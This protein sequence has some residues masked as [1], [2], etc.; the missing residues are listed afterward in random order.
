MK[1]RVLLAVALLM[2][3]ASNSR[4]EVVATFGEGWAEVNDGLKT[5][6]LKGSEHEMGR[7]Y[8]Y[9]VGDEIDHTLEVLRE[10]A[11]KQ[12]PK[13]RLLP[14]W[15]FRGIGRA[16]GWAWW[17][18]FPA[19]IKDHLNGVIEGS[20]LR[21]KPVELSKA[22]LGFMNGIIDSAGVL[23]ASADS[24]ESQ[25]PP[26]RIEAAVR[27]KFLE[28]MG[29]GALRVNCD[30]F[31]AWGSRTVDGKT[32]QTR[33]VDVPTGQGLET[34]PLVIIY[35]PEGRIPFVTAAFSG[36]VGVFT[37]MNAEGVAM[38]QVWAFSRH[39]GLIQPWQL[40]VREVMM[41]ARTGRE[42]RDSMLAYKKL[43]Y[44][45]NFV[46]AGAGPDDGFS[47]EGNAREMDWF[48]ANDPRES[49]LKFNGESVNIPLT[50][51]VFRADAAFSPRIRYAQNGANG[52][53]GDPR[54]ANSYKKRYKG[55]SDMIL[56]FE[57]RGIKIGK[58]E[59]E[60]IS[61]DTAMRGG[62]LQTAVYANTDREMWVAYSKIHEDGSVTQAYDREY[63]HVP[64]SK[65]LLDR[66]PAD[67][68]Y[69]VRLLRDGRAIES[70]RRAT[71]Y[72][73]LLREVGAV[74][75]GARPGDLIEVLGQ[76]GER[77]ELYR[78]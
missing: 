32:F 15:A 77:L 10:V 31:A 64:F 13:V 9:F 20:K 33:N 45:S 39:V 63:Q 19:N 17:W 61:R 55:Q 60:K 67:T 74:R 41:S 25:T 66:R 2:L 24:I 4:A 73:E 42:A 57:S 22:D 54:E 26:A 21:E 78:T 3:M 58:E 70:G 75:T 14:K 18:T 72:E 27:N 12:E 51:A 50:E 46:F 65:Y 6:H 1:Q 59:A 36:M 29:L 11:I 35:K 16:L 23:R 30:T 34:H 49:E 44:G 56:D 28:I 53:Y 68:R 5:L 76:D 47:L 48:G 8:G 71:G 43:S 38:G 62:S 40:M 69:E 37:G 52:P 7:Q